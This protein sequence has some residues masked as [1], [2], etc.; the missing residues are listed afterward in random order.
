MEA[1]SDNEKVSTATFKSKVFL[2]TGGGELTQSG[3]LFR[4]KLRRK[5]AVRKTV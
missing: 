5:K 2:G 3:K 1:F 4:R